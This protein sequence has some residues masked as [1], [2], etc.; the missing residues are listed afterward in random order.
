MNQKLKKKTKEEKLQEETSEDPTMKM[1]RMRQV[2]KIK[3]K[4]DKQSCV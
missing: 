1:K 4:Q 2:N 3:G